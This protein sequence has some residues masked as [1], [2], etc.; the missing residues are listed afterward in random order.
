M[1]VKVS[2]VVA[3]MFVRK[4]LENIFVNLLDTVVRILRGLFCAFF[5]HIV[6]SPY[7]Y[8]FDF[9]YP[10]V[11]EHSFSM[12]GDDPILTF[13]LIQGF[14]R[15]SF[16]IRE[17]TTVSCSGLRRLAVSLLLPGHA[18]RLSQEF[19]QGVYLLTRLDEIRQEP[20]T[21]NLRITESDPGCKVLQ[22]QIFHE[23]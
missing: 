23:R 18:Q 19:V 22:F 21:R 14:L 13:G 20:W 12:N 16:S 11:R 5:A 1:I 15:Y 10:S 2:R 3:S 17:P 9:V 4:D 7:R 8:N 6:A